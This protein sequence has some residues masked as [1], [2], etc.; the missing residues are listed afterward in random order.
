MSPECT[1]MEFIELIKTT[2]VDGVRIRTHPFEMLEGTLCITGH[3]LL[4]STREDTTRE[5]W[6][7]V[8]LIN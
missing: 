6:V 3:H 4:L 1:S 5:L 8:F 7:G 2:K